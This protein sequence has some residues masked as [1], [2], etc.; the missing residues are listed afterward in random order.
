MAD[1]ERAVQVKEFLA[2]LA[3]LGCDPSAR[4]VVDPF[5]PM[6]AYYRDGTV[7]LRWDSTIDQIRHECTHQRLKHKATNARDWELNE[8]E[9]RLAELRARDE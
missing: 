1:R 4:V 8:R 6:P 3:L 7:F 9:A 2:L 5:L